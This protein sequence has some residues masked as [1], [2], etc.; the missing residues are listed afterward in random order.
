[1]RQSQG[2]RKSQYWKLPRG[3]V[4]QD[5]QKISIGFSTRDVMVT[6]AAVDVA[7]WWEVKS[8]WSE[9]S[10]VGEVRKQIIQV[11]SSFKSVSVKGREGELA[12]GRYLVK[13]GLHLRWQDEACLNV[14][15]KDPLHW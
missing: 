9:V 13:G 15:K 6:L 14:D 1:M 5:D 2:D 10:T 12:A 7:E 8:A 3:D 11:V 4:Q